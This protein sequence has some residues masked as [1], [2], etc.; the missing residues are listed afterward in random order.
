MKI[1]AILP[2]QIAKDGIGYDVV[3]HNPGDVFEMDKDNAQSMIDQGRA[4][5]CDGKTITS[6][7]AETVV[8]NAGGAP[9]DKSVKSAPRNKSTK[10]KG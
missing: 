9:E 3:T 8:K 4:V 6:D 7:S 1:K 2:I 5:A 10:K